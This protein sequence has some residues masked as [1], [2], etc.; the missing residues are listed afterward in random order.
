VTPPKAKQDLRSIDH[1]DDLLLLTRVAAH[2]TTR[3]TTPFGND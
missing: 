3:P 1:G 2:K